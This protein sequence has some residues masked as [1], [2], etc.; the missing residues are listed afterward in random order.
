MVGMMAFLKVS[1]TTPANEAYQAA[2]AVATPNQPPFSQFILDWNAPTVSKTNV[3]VSSTNTA[4]TAPLTRTTG[5]SYR[6]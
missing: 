4:A 3:M 5:S 6:R 2:A 1:F